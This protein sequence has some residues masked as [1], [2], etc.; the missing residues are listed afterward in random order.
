M[1]DL[2]AQVGNFVHSFNHRF[3]S[4]KTPTPTISEQSFD[5]AVNEK[6]QS[7]VAEA[8][9]IV[10]QLNCQDDLSLEGQ[11]K[12]SIQAAEYTVVIGSNGLADG[13]ITAK[14]LLVKGKVVGEISVADRIIIA[15]TGTIVGNLQAARVELENGAK[16]K[17]IIEIDPIEQEATATDSASDASIEE[18]APSVSA[19][20]A[21]E[22]S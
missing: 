21:M 7:I 10:G 14:N 20:S 17:G 8:V 11:F 9:A 18:S 12:G 1:K 3:G 5:L 15:K 16:Y 2:V 19:A 6:Q 22:T 4:E 13:D